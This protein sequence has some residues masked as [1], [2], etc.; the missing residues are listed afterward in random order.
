LVAA[1]IP[2]ARKFQVVVVISSGRA[3]TGLDFACAVVMQ[4]QNR[5][6]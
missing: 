1:T 4:M 3:G 2:R 6:E 5:F